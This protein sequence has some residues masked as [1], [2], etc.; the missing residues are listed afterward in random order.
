[1]QTTPMLFCSK[2]HFTVAHNDYTST[3]GHTVIL[4]T[5]FV[6]LL[7]CCHEIG[8]LAKCAYSSCTALVL[9]KGR[10][11]HTTQQDTLN[12]LTLLNAT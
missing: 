7:V 4:H 6:Y 1:M 11:K 5:I 12:L 8:H 2:R 9:V 10:S 3:L